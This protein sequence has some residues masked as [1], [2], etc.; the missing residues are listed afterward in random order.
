M[1]NMKFFNPFEG[2][3]R[4]DEIKKW[5]DQSEE[6]EQSLIIKLLEEFKNYS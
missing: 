5:L 1:S 2:D 4:D 3:I 6:K